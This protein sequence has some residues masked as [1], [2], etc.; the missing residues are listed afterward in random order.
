MVRDTSN[1][2]ELHV[3]IEAGLAAGKIVL[4]VEPYNNFLIN[5]GNDPTEYCLKLSQGIQSVEWLCVTQRV[6]VSLVPL[7]SGI[8]PI[9]K[10]WLQLPIEFRPQ[11][12]HSD[13]PDLGVEKSIPFLEAAI[14]GASGY[15]LPTIIPIIPHPKIGGST[16]TDLINNYE[17]ALDL[18]QIL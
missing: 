8:N 14:Q 17:G 9:H 12:Y 7:L 2:T 4:D 1:P 16:S 15:P 3:H 5:P 6:G 11:C 10:A 18:W 13:N